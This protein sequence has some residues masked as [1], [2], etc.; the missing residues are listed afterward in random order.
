MYGW[1]S[2]TTTA[3]D[4]QTRRAP[5]CGRR[6]APPGSRRTAAR[7]AGDARASPRRREARAARARRRGVSSHE[8]RRTAAAEAR[9]RSGRTPAT[10]PSQTTM[11]AYSQNEHPRPQRSTPAARSGTAIL[12]ARTNRSSTPSTNGTTAATSVSR[13][14]Q[15]LAARSSRKRLSCV[16]KR[17]PRRASME[18]I[19]ASAARPSRVNRS[20]AIG[21]RP[22]GRVAGRNLGIAG[23]LDREVTAAISLRERALLPGGERDRRAPTSCVATR[24]ERGLRAAAPRRC[25][26]A[27]RDE[28]ARRRA[29]A[30]AC[31]RESSAR[32]GPP[33]PSRTIAAIALSACGDV[34][35]EPACAGASVRA[36]VGGDE[37]ERAVGHAGSGRSPAAHSHAPARR[38]PRCRRRCRPS[39]RPTPALS[40]WATTTIASGDWPGT[41]VT[42]FRS[43]TLP[44]SGRSASQTSSSAGSPSAASDSVYQSAASS[45]FRRARHPRRM[46]E[47]E[48][49][50]ERAAARRRTPG[51]AEAGAAFQLPRSRTGTASS[52]GATTMAATRTRR[53]FTGLSTVPR[54]GRCLR[55]PG[56]AASIAGAIVGRAAAP[57]LRRDARCRT[58]PPSSSSTTRSRSRR[59]SPSRSSGTAIASCRR[60]T[61][62]RRSAASARRTSI[63]SCST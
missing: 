58:P 33:I 8:R 41:T 57:G 53:V 15:P 36:R 1:T 14:V 13:I 61:A 28:D 38:A 26:R 7:S 18:P 59:C 51:R 4:G 43:S 24:R 34:F 20:I 49:R 16:W 44:S 25:A 46:L 19:S 48:L 10:P 29:R 9:R 12:R 5:R 62:R 42:K 6:G 63:S 11:P 31:D 3:T 47:R 21:A 23:L 40:R 39:S 35:R 55:P 52:A 37:D 17:L 32:R 30:V 56:R 2:A 54:R 27:R 60:V 45:G 50:R 22:A